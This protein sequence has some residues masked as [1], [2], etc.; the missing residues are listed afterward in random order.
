[1]TSMKIV[2][3]LRTPTTLVHLDR[4]FFYPLD[5]GRPILIKPALRAPS[6]LPTTND[7]QSIKRKQ[8]MLSYVISY[9][10]L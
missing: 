8:N 2:Q 7:N 5:L 6:F 10:I 3:F 1:M 4:K 9:V